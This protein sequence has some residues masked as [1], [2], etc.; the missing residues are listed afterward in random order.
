LQAALGEDSRAAAALLAAREFIQLGAAESLMAAR[1]TVGHP[2]LS[3]FLVS[4]LQNPS[5]ERLLA[6]YLDEG[7]QAIRAEHMGIGSRNGLSV[8][9]RLLVHRALEL[10]AGK[11][12]LAHNHPS[13]CLQPSESDQRATAVIER[14]CRD[15]GI[16]LVDHCIV[17]RGRVF[18][19]RQGRELA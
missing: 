5:E 8:R 10:N 2:Q 11:I 9:T 14:I 6:I 18:S 16:E 19:M 15:L 1:V 12:I 17:A 3:A 7:D 4:E 13:G